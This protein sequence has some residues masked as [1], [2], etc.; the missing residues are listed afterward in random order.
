MIVYSSAVLIHIYGV[1][2]YEVQLLFSSL[3]LCC[4]CLH[5]AIG[6][7]KTISERCKP[8]LLS[9]CGTSCAYITNLLHSV[10]YRD[11]VPKMDKFSKRALLAIEQN[12]NDLTGLQLGAHTS[13]YGNRLFSSTDSNDYDRLGTAIGNNTED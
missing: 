5:V 1:Q 2:E 10:Q 9:C 3:L 4:L 6:H 13:S 7:L 8:I 12:S 11:I